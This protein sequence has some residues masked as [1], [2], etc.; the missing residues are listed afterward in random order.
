MGIHK[1]RQAFPGSRFSL[2]NGVLYPVGLYNSVAFVALVP[3]TFIYI[4]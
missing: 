3:Q 2:M 1:K 4:K